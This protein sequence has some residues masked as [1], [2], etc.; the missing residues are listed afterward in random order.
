MLFFV[1]G[2]DAETRAAVRIHLFTLLF[3]DCKRMCATIVSSTNILASMTHLLNVTQHKLKLYKARALK[4]GLKFVAGPD[5]TPKWM[6]PMLLF[7][8]LHEKVVL[9]AKRKAA[10]QDICSHAWKWYDMNSGN[11]KEYKAANNRIID[12]AFWEGEP[13]VKINNGRKYVIYFKTMMQ[14][15]FIIVYCKCICKLT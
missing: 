13:S 15:R 7:I 9:G 10:L 11:W 4:S 12:D 5:I 8:D 3:E 2:G 1:P 14:V 6:T